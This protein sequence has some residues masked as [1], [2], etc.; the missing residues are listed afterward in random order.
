ALGAAAAAGHGVR[1]RALDADQRAVDLRRRSLALG[2]D[3]SAAS[4]RAAA[5]ASAAGLRADRAAS[6]HQRSAPD[7]AVR[8]R[9]LDSRLLALERLQPR[10]GRWPLVG[11]ARGLG[12][13]ARSLGARPDGPVPRAWAL[14][15]LR[16]DRQGAKAPRRIENG[17][18]A[19]SVRP[20]FVRPDAKLR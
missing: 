7:R 4:L 17:S 5:A 6:A 16:R 8:R 1:A 18:D 10:L 2:A 13:G 19:K 11:S 15:S 20:F 9:G 14:A 12:V 3:A